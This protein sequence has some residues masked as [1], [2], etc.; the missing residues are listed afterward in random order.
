MR[1]RRQ[2]TC[3]FPAMFA[4]LIFYVGNSVL[5]AQTKQILTWQ[6]DLNYLQTISNE[7]LAPNL[8]AIVQIRNGVEFWLKMH[9]DSKVELQAAPPQPWSAEEL[10]NQVSLLRGAVQSIL[11]EDPSRPFNLGMTITSVTAE[12]SP[13][14]PVADTLERNEIVNREAV[15]VATA[16]DYLPGVA[17]DHVSSNRNEA[18]I[19]IRGFSSRG[20]VPLYLDGIPIAMPYDSTID[21]NRYVTSDYAEVQVAKGYS[22]P[23]LGP[24][25][26][27]GSIN[28]VTKQ[29]EK[30]L[31]ADALIGTGSGDGLLASMHLGSRWEH[32]YVQGSVDWLQRDFMPISGNFTLNKFQPTY[33]RLQSDS[34]DEKYNGRIAW[35]PKGHDQY[36][37]SFTNQ[38]GDKGVP[39]YAGPNSG[40]TFGSAA[41]RRWPYWNNTSYYFL[42]DT[43]LGEASSIKFRGYYYQFNNEFDFYDDATF[44]TMNKSSSN[45]SF[46]DDHS[47][48]LSTEFTNRSISRN[49][50]G[51][52]FFFKDD[53]HKEYNEYP[54][55]SPFP[56]VTATL[57]ERSQVFSI[58]LQDVVT[59][60]SHARATFGFSADYLRGL[61]AQAFNSA[62]TDVVPVICA[63]SPANSSFAG[64]TSHVWNVNPQ[65]S[66]SYTLSVRD[67]L[68]ATFADRGR[69]PILKE[70]YSY[71][72]G[73]AIPNP[74]LEP[75]HSTNWDVGYSHAFGIHTI[76]QVDYFY[77]RLRNAIQSVYVMDTE[78]LCNNT[79]SL[80]GYCSQN[81]NIAREVH[82]GLE[83]N[84]RSTP[85]PRLILDINYSYINRTLEY[86]F[87]SNLDVSQVL[88]TIQILPT[89][90]R[91]KV[92]AN[93]TVR[94][95]H[96]V[97]AIA[98][99]RY[100]GGIT[101]QDTTYKTPPGNLA[102]ATSYGTVDFGA[103]VPV[104]AGI[105]A[106]V[107]VRNLLDRDYYYTPGF[108]EPGRN[109]YLNLRY[110]F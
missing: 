110:R 26:L 93:A 95:P 51:A 50:F 38:K 64:C 48:G 68:F 23:L 94:L 10:R 96:Q 9:P 75:E 108:P 85:I 66:L 105:S 20:Q 99:Y 5:Q 34:R 16:L 14:S 15:N 52:S 60:S 88:T 11:K 80:A 19:R 21:F 97:L 83:I 92:V 57:K 2:K 81:V 13:L 24:N 43:A 70:S 69:F 90:P 17:I 18:G 101:V 36:V 6:D 107:G 56:F 62:L 22:S 35:T 58:G 53:T 104:H 100:E 109:W 1:S 76:G 55:R 33:E 46:Y 103:V 61:Q 77:E 49:L 54:A 12:A 84:V 82:Q 39:L 42:T 89:L 98:N 47:S 44:S 71:R 78:S 67:T 7:D 79:G 27:G 65:A 30:K 31:D 32:F 37:F 72:L 8:A 40:A 41:Y 4:L 25:A 3:I 29:P 63:S 28:L 45:H 59:I 91:N 73:S 87:G 102:Y 86:N 74:D 106:Q